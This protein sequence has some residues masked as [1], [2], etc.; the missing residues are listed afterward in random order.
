MCLIAFRKKNLRNVLKIGRGGWERNS[1][2]W[3]RV[4]KFRNKIQNLWGE[5]FEENLS[6][7]A[8]LQIFDQI[9]SEIKRIS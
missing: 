6:V 2:I 4:S 1:V 3:K 7:M 8:R 9:L 5:F